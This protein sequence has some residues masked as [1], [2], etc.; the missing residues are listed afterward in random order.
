MKLFRKSLNSII[1]MAT[2]PRRYEVAFHELTK[3]LLQSIVHGSLLP[4][5]HL[6]Y[7]EEINSRFM[8]VGKNMGK[9]LQEAGSGGMQ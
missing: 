8:P 9:R 7:A 1:T 2:Y 5:F 6:N 4:A 3:C